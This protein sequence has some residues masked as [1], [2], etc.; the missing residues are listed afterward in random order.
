MHRGNFSS[1]SPHKKKPPFFLSTHTAV[2]IDQIRSTL[3]IK[4]LFIINLM[5]NHSRYFVGIVTFFGQCTWIYLQL[6]PYMR[7]FCY[8]LLLRL[9]GPFQGGG[10]GRQYLKDLNLS[11]LWEREPCSRVLASIIRTLGQV[12]CCFTQ[13]SLCLHRRTVGF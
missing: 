9:D 13:R 12:Q 1:S 10:S 2:G 6:S 5:I 7:D 3:S 11:C 8:I 4:N